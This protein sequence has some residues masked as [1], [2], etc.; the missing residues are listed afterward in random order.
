MQQDRENGYFNRAAIGCSRAV[1]RPGNASTEDRR[2]VSVGAVY[3]KAA[4][5]ACSDTFNALA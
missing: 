4:G 5:G 1:N 3:F 2:G